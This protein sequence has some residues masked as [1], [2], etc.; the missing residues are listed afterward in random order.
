[1]NLLEGKTALVFGVANDHSIAWG[2]ARTMHAHGARLGFS[3][4]NEAL[5]RR[6][7]PLAHSV[8][9]TFVEPCDVSK[10]EDIDALFAKAKADLGGLDILVHAV[11]FANRE[12]LLGPYYETSRAGFHLALDISVYSFTALARA[13]LPMLNQGASLLTLTYYG[14]QKVVPHYN[15]MGIAKAALEASTRYLAADL[16]PRGIRV[17]AI[18][19]GPIRTLAAAGVSGFKRMHR[20][21]AGSA[22]L[23]SNVTIDDIGGAAV[24]LSS[25]LAQRVTGE[26]LFVDSGYNILGASLPVEEAN[27]T[28]TS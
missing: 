18:S 8:G 24:W 25:D 21:F 12:E 17:N 5:E 20:D 14:G 23:R 6:V 1:M 9:A 4:A 10:D 2:I 16:G 27:T 13:A 15:V 7:R 26:V 19:A 22:P 11:A 28:P 3:Y